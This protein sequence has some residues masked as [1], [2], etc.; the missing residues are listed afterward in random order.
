MV[1]AAFAAANR[2]SIQTGL[3][4]NR[5]KPVSGNGR[6][7]FCA[8]LWLWYSSMAYGLELDRFFKRSDQR[9]I[10]MLESGQAEAAA[11]EFTDPQ[12]RGVSRY[13]AGLY[14]EAMEDFSL[15]EDATGLYNHGTAAARAGDYNQS[16]ASLEKALELAPEDTNIAHNLD[17]AKKLKDLAEQEQQQEQQQDGQDQDKQQ[18]SESEDSDENAE[19]DQQSESQDS[20]QEQQDSDQSEGNPDNTADSQTETQENSGEMDADEQD[21]TSESDQQDAE[22]LRDMMQQEQMDARPNEPE[23][24]PPEQQNQQQLAA[25]QPE[26][27]S[28]DDQATEQWLRRIPDDASQLLRNKIRLNHLIEYPQVDDMQEPW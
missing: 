27:V 15:S 8:L 19:S 3:V 11:N 6:W 2:Y 20:Q 13:R 21:Q 9:G 1:D 25:S 17:I 16:V 22:D 18:Q 28:E 5:L 7:L 4:M 24:L 12:W 10:E 26:S 23:E 14:Q